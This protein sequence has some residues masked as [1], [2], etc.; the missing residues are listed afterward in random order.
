MEALEIHYRIHASILK[1][2][3]L[4]EDKPLSRNIGKIFQKY[5]KETNNGLFSNPAP[6]KTDENTVIS[7]N[8]KRPSTGEEEASSI[9]RRRLSELTIFEDVAS[10]VEDMLKILESGT[11]PK[12]D[13]NDDI[14]MIIDSDDDATVTNKRL[15]AY[16]LLS[17]KAMQENKTGIS[18]S[19]T[20]Q[21]PV[22]LPRIQVRN[23]QE[24]MDDMMKKCMAN[25]PEYKSETDTDFEAEIDKV[26][27]IK[28]EN[29][30]VKIK[31]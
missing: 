26:K 16:K 25:Q 14:V 2:L 30:Q 23:A 22:K 13:P 8:L 7:A 29:N 11:S 19:S 31:N 17:K 24:I 15:E 21:E 1:Y 4:H 20:E 6:V 9:K 10:V 3:E 27:D 5:L 28:T 12:N 18:S